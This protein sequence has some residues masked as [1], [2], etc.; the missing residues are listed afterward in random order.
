MKNF[1][2]KKWSYT[3]ILIV[4]MLFSYKEVSA[5]YPVNL[6]CNAEGTLGEPIG[7]I[8][9]WN[10]WFTNITFAGINHNRVK[11]GWITRYTSEIGSVQRGQKYTLSVTVNAAGADFSFQY[12]AAYIDWNRDGDCGIR[13]GIPTPDTGES[14][15]L[16][17]GASHPQTMTIEIT[18]PMDAVVGTTWLRVMLDGDEGNGDYSCYVGYGEIKD[19]PVEVTAGGSAPTVTTTAAT[20]ISATSATLGGNVTADGGAAVSERGVV[21]S[22]TDSTPT[23]AEG[24][25]KDTNGSGTGIFSESIGSLSAGTTYYYNAYAINSAGTSYGTTTSFT[26]SSATAPDI[27]F[28][29]CPDNVRA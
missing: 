11:D 15:L 4:L 7:G 1:Y 26:T 3:M 29:N 10:D 17:Q 2:L 19:F 6:Y 27:E 12:I 20:S 5:Q 14:Y 23:I 9:A 24:A 8:Y 16:G 13:S 18:V 28:T 22:T 25:T 21:Y